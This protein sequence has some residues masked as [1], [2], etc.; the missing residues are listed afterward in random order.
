MI[1]KLYSIRD[2]KANSYSEPF[3]A[4]N[5]DVA[6]RKY[7]YL[8]SKSEMIAY[9]TELYSVAQFDFEHGEVV[10]SEKQ[11]ITNYSEVKQ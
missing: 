1:Y 5:D 7:A 2:I 8:M 6:V 3:S 4:P 9:D 10:L 11:Y